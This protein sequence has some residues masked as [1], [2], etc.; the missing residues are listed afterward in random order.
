MTGPPRR[1]EFRLI[2]ELFAPLATAPGAHGLGDDCAYLTLPPD[3][4]LVLKADAIVSGVH[5]L[6]DTAPEHVAAKALRVNLSDLAA[7][8]ARPLGYLQTMSLPPELDDAWLQRYAAGLAADQARYGLGLL[9]GD[10]TATPGPL[11]ISITV[12]G[13]VPRGS[14]PLRSGAKA[15]DRVFVTGSIGDAALGLA[16]LRGTYAAD[17]ADRDFLVDRYN[18]PQPRLAEGGTLLGIAHATADVS[19][20]LVADL[21]HIADASGV[22]IEIDAVRVPL[23][24]AARRAVALDPTWLPRL[25]AAGDDYEIAFTAAATPP[26]AAGATEI[27]RVVAGSG[28]TVRDA[29]GQPLPLTRAGY[30]HF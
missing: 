15:G 3:Q 22:A 27:G 28:V 12:F 6:P 2:A 18:L 19:D 13:A 4:E 7:K 8:G 17:A 29:S 24:A 26:A 21:G 23:S 25:I 20:G 11:T 16:V 14:A 5:F 9:G 10:L 30:T 1:G